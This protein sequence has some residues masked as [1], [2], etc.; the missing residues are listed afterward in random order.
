MTF[1]IYIAVWLGGHLQV[2]M[3]IDLSIYQCNAMM[4]N[5]NL[6]KSTTAIDHDD[7][8]LTSQAC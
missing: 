2:M 5:Q 8:G 6:Q 1:V 3:T 7:H 4:L